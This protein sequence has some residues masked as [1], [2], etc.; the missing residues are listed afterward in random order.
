MVGQALRR[1]KPLPD[2]RTWPN[3]SRELADCT[4]A[5]RTMVDRLGRSAT[6]YGFAVETVDG[7]VKLAV[8][9]EARARALLLGLNAR[10][11]DAESRTRRQSAE[12][13]A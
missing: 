7:D 9:I 11:A 4:V 1:P 6:E 3:V 2:A 10:E 8:E 5:L 13:G 12:A